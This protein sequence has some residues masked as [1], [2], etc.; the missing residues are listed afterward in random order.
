MAESQKTAGR[1]GVVKVP[2]FLRAE[3]SREVSG[4]TSK[5]AAVGAAIDLQIERALAPEPAHS[6][7][8]D[9]RVEKPRERLK[10]CKDAARELLDSD[11]ERREV[12]AA[13]KAIREARAE[14]ERVRAQVSAERAEKTRS[15]LS[16]HIADL[17]TRGR[18][19]LAALKT[20]A[21]EFGAAFADAARVP[22]LQ[23]SLFPQG[24]PDAAFWFAQ[25]GALD[26]CA[27][28][29]DA[30]LAPSAHLNG[31]VP[32]KIAGFP[33][34]LRGR[35]ARRFRELVESCEPA[36]CGSLSTWP[37][38]LNELCFFMQPTAAVLEKLKLVQPAPAPAATRAPPQPPAPV[39][40]R[41]LVQVTPNNKG[42]IIYEPPEKA[43]HYISKG[44]AELVDPTTAP[45]P[46]APEELTPV[47]LLADGVATGNTRGDVAHFPA[48]RAR[49]LVAAGLARQATRDELKAGRVNLG[50]P[51]APERRVPVAARRWVEYKGGPV[52]LRLLQGMGQWGAGEV[53]YFSESDAAEIV[54]AELAVRLDAPTVR[55]DARTVSPTLEG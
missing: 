55:V 48:S 23:Q 20:I 2:D 27:R 46:A 25:T 13:A 24:H 54:A 26:D 14:L 34:R 31:R 47:L 6:T 12:L 44:W 50:E 18:T 3:F 43:E 21:V 32:V 11:G 16:Q 9:R 49:Q 45:A 19:A 52:A 7:D 28:Q 41:L 29:L 5:A 33:G 53:A 36:E 10:Q 17:Q 51:P 30:M 39:P 40:I 4:S 15:D 37:W 1:A 8:N 38:G 35:D 22:G 42:E